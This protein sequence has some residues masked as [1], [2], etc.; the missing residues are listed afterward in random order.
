MQNYKY[1]KKTLPFSDIFT[2]FIIYTSEFTHRNQDQEYQLYQN[3]HSKQIHQP[4]YDI[5]SS[6]YIELSNF[7]AR[8]TNGNRQSRGIKIAHF[9]KG[10]GHLATKLNE[11][12]KL[13]FRD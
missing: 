10:P 11:T 2:S 12:N 3:S 8:Y 7:Y 1:S 5:Q 13:C 9:N 6:T 4:C